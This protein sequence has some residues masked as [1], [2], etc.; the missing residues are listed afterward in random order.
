[1]CRVFVAIYRDGLQEPMKS[2]FGWTSDSEPS[3]DTKAANHA[4]MAFEMSGKLTA[5]T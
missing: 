5:R 2:W 3:R 4:R 1:M